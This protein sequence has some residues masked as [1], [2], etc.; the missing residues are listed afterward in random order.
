[1]D[2]DNLSYF[3]KKCP[4]LFLN[5]S[6]FSAEFIQNAIKSPNWHSHRKY[7]CKAK[8]IDHRPPLS[9]YSQIFVFERELGDIFSIT[10]PAFLASQAK[11]DNKDKKDT[12]RRGAVVLMS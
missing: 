9:K 2:T 3:P 6:V 1:M 11:K 4:H 12:N 8:K 7:H 10:E 5:N